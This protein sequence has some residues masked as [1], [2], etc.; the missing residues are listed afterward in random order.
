MI[1][2][3]L[4][5]LFHVL[6]QIF[7]SVLRYIDVKFILTTVFSTLQFYF[8]Q[9]DNVGFLRILAVLTEKGEEFAVIVNPDR[10]M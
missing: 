8:L 4:Y 7:Y 1:F 2:F 9:H 10:Q 6:P 5:F 3:Y